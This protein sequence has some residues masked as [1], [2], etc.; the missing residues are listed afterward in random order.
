MRPAR[1]ALACL[2]A[3]A[4]AAMDKTAPPT[5]RSP[6][7][8]T[9]FGVTEQDPYRWLENAADPEVTA[10]SEAQDARTRAWLDRLPFRETVHER[11]AAMASQTSPSYSGLVQAGGALFASFIQPP[12]QQAMIARLGPDAD[13][14]HAAIIVDPNVL[15]PT[16]GTEI[17]WFVPSPDGRKI[18][19]SLSKNGSEDGTLHVFDA[20]TGKPVNETIPAVQ[21][22]TGGG[23]L[24]WRADGSGFWYTRYPGAER[25]DADRH[26]YQQIYYHRLGD[27]PARDSYVLGRN[28]PKIA[29]ITLSN[30]NNPNVVV[31]AVARG[32]GGQFEHFLI[33]PDNTSR[34][35]TD[36]DDSIASVVAGADNT[37]YLTSFQSAP[38][39]KVLTLPAD[40]PILA[41]AKTLIPESDGSIQ[42]PDEFAGPPV[43]VTPHAIYL[44]ELVGGPS[45]V[46]V[47]D[48]TGKRLPDLPLPQIAAVH[49][50][51]G[52]GDGRL[53]YQIETYFR[54]PYYALFSE[55]SGI[56]TDTKLAET[57]TV[58]FDDADV[59]RVFATSR[60]GTRIPVNIIARTSTR[61]NGANP[62]MLTGYGGFNIAMEPQALRGA[63]RL[64]LD[65]GG[66]LAIA[67][68]RGGDE[69]GADWHS[70]G[71]LTHKQNV[72]D[73]FAAAARLLIEK[74]YTSPAHLA[75]R[76]GS[77]GGLL[78][79]VEI[80][81]H[82]D[83][84]RAVVAQVGIYDMLRTE[85]DP[86][87]AFNVTEYGS[88]KDEDQFRALAA[89][90]PYHHV[91]PGTKYPA[92]FMATGTHDGRVNPAHSRKMVAA[93][94]AATLSGYPILLSINSHAGHGIGSAR[95][96]RIDQ[97]ADWL[98]F[99]FE[100]LGMMP[101]SGA[102]AG[103]RR[104]LVRP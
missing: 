87:G 75:A 13:P 40:A 4:T 55:A 50:V 93:L 73:D 58:N 6:T 18:A 44:R 76:G 63:I 66:V 14:A 52:A 53:L 83:L 89:Y 26:F 70:N 74:H 21:Y 77:N 35:I 69:Y 32:D 15:D 2:A 67:N 31:A 23:S 30:R 10:W 99:L 64:W 104:S 38:R 27:D 86:N 49:S 80:T 11:L 17:D 94:Q 90:S 98:S 62:A 81:Q 72:F 95:S 3:L 9:Y 92:V 47:Y 34:Q 54:R 37:L 100:E 41:N 24:A 61:L 97:E 78:M 1:L 36:F 22:P 102:G 29:E 12:K 25:P 16:G 91:K 79:G 57:S 96:V 46:A 28:F 43:T 7:T 5:R 85:L 20:A 60:D 82:P 59:R 45:R 48:H 103:V 101:D 88:V 39:G 8:D 51:V 68:L 65:A 71:A 84:Y 42:L 19:V 56:A 33:A